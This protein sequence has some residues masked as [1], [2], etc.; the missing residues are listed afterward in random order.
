M[1][2]VAAEPL[3]SGPPA[4]KFLPRFAGPGVLLSGKP[5]DAPYW[6]AVNVAPFCTVQSGTFTVLPSG[7]PRPASAP[8]FLMMLT[9]VAVTADAGS[10]SSAVHTAAGAATAIPHQDRFMSV[11]PRCRPADPALS[12]PNDRSGE[13][14]LDISGASSGSRATLT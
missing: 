10:A 8:G 14:N 5:P 6:T 7:E 12:P 13:R 3:L 4:K 2:C 11:P 1:V 9:G